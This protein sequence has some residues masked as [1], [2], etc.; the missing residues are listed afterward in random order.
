LV[1]N[2]FD[3]SSR[4]RPRYCTAAAGLLSSTAA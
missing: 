3:L 4:C 2:D 1:V